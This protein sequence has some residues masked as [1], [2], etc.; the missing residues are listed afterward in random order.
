ME[1][2]EID[3]LSVRKKIAFSAIIF[4]TLAVVFF[5]ATKFTLEYLEK[6]KELALLRENPHG[7]GS[8]RL[9]PNLKV[10]T[11]VSN[12]NIKISTNSHGMRWREVDLNNSHNKVR[13]AFV[14]DSFTF[15]CWAE[16][17]QSTFVG[18]FEKNLP[19]T[20]YEVLNFGIGGYGL[21]DIELLLREEVSRFHP[22]YV[23]LAFF[24]GNDFRDTYLGNEK[25]NI[26]EGTARWNSDVIREKLPPEY[27]PDSTALKLR[28]SKAAPE[29]TSIFTNE[30]EISGVFTSY[31]FWSQTR[32]PTVADSARAVSL[33]TLNRIDAYVRSRDM[34]LLIVAIPYREQIYVER[35]TGKD[36]DLELPQRHVEAFAAENG[37]PYLDLL[38]PLREYVRDKREDIFI[39]GDPH[40]NAHGHRIVGG[41]I[42]NWFKEI[43]E[44][45]DNSTNR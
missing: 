44:D 26:V 19:D 36:Y 8:F 15:G 34:N 7:T 16:S 41:F 32:Y 25:Y 3:S 24:N 18:V 12:T 28:N 1:Q 20:T 35:V 37:V 43:L 30:L 38:P 21:S 27:R 14:G 31:T 13:I 11:N 9:R 29:S 22:A 5:A 40:F 23:I 10:S 4:S 45:E 17:I 6:P 42:G 33:E 2:L 39:P